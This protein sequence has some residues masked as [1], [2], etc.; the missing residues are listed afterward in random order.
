MAENSEVNPSENINDTTDQLEG[1]TYEILQNRLKK[2]ASDLQGLLKKLNEERKKVF[3]SIETVLVGTE[4]VTTDNNCVP[5]DMVPV[6][7]IFLF[8]YNVHLGLKTDTQLSDVFSIYTYHDHEFHQEDLGLIN[9]KV[10]AED[11]KKLYKYYKN[12][13]F[14]KFFKNG[15]DLHM[16]FRIGKDVT[17][18]KTFKW[19]IIGDKL[20]YIDNR[21]DHEFKFPEQHDFKWKKTTRDNFRQ[22]TFSHVSIEDKVFVE[23]TGGDLT[24]KVEDNTDDGKGIYSEPV[25]HKDQTL[26]DAE[27]YYAIVGN[28]VILKIRP[29]QED[30]RYIVFN[31]KVNQARRIDELQDSCILLPDD[32]GIIFR[33]GYYLQA[34]EFKKFDTA[35]TSMIFEK[36]IASPNG[37]DYL[38]VFYNRST[39]TY[40]LMHYN[41]IEQKVENHTICHGFSIFENGEMCLFRADEEAKKH[42][43][44]QIWQTPYTGPDFAVEGSNDSYLSKIGNK[45]VVRAMA[46]CNELLNLIHKDD[47]Y[48]GLYVDLIRI[49]TDIL[50]SYHWLNREET[51]GLN[52]PLE[53][54][55]QVA[56]SAV[57]EF[58]KVI[59]IKEATGNHIEEV[60]NTAD[61]L[62][63]RI[64]KGTAK[65]IDVYVLNLADLRKVRGQVVSLK[66]LRY[67]DLEVIDRYDDQLAEFYKNVSQDCV[68]FLL[69]DRALA[70]Y[71]NKVT[72][73]KERINEVKK[74]VEANEIEIQINKVSQELEM[75]I[76]IVSNLKI[77]DATQTTRI[78]DNIS[79]IY[80][81]FNQL[82]AALKKTRKELMGVE[83][84][85]EFNAQIKLVDQGVINFIDLCDSP[86]KCDEYLSKTM[87]QLEELEAKFSEFDEFIEKIS[88]KREEVYNAF[89][90]RKLNLIEE[91]NR[92]ANT[93][94]QAA[95]RILKAIENR[96]SRFE[97]IAEINGYYAADMMI[98]KIRGI[99]DELG[100]MGDTVKSEDIVSRLK[101]LKEDAVRQLKDRS[102]L[103]VDGQDVIKFGPHKFAVN[104]QPFDLTIVRKEDALYFH[105]AGTNFFEAIDN[106]IVATYSAVLDQVLVS[107]NDLVYRAEY[108]AYM[109]L[110]DV[111]TQPDTSVEDLYQMS[112]KDLNEYVVKF[113]SVRFDEGYIKGVHD[114]DAAHILRALVNLIH[115]SDLLRYPATA[116]AMAALFWKKY[117]SPDRKELLDHQLKGAGIILQVFPDSREFDNLLVSLRNDLLDFT[118]NTQL[119]TPEHADTAAEYLFYE[120][121]RGD[122]FVIDKEADNL[123]HAFK[124]H[125]KT[126]K[127]Q[128]QFDDSLKG[129]GNNLSQAFYHVKNWVN[130]YIQ[131]QDTNENWKDYAEEVSVILLADDY[132][133]SKVVH[134]SLNIFLEG[135]QGNHALLSDN[136]YELH[137]NH[138]TQK[139]KKYRRETVPLFEAYNRL[140]KEM[141]HDFAESLRLE[142][143]RPRIMSSFVRNR[144]IDEVYLPLIGANLAKQIG[145][146]GSEK[147]TDLMGLLLL[148]SPPG[149]G[150]TTLMEYIANRLGV[151]FMKINGPALGHDVVALD[152]KQAPNSGAREELKKLNLAFE[153]GDNVMIY[154]DDIQHCNPEFLQKFISLCDAQRK[155]E[156]V[157]KGKSRTYDFRGKRVCV[158]MAG[159][160]YTESGEKFRIPDM[161]VNRAD[162]YN[163]GDI[164]GDTEDVFKL[165]YIENCLT[166]NAVLGKLAGKS[167]KDVLSVLKIA[168]SGKQEGVDFEASH[169]PEEISEYVELIKKLLVV[170]DVILTVN[171]QYIYSAAQSDEYRTEPPFKLQ[172]SYR[173]MNKIA[174]KVVSVMNEDELQNLIIS[175]YESESQTLT[176][177]AEANLLKFK[178]LIDLMSPPEKERWEDIITLFQKKQ[179]LAGYGEGN[180]TGLVVKEMG[181]ISKHL[182]GIREEMLLL[183]LK[184][185]PKKDENE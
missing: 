48:S 166:S 63:K 39:G 51:F 30:Y 180:Q 5:C 137:F 25:D 66:E 147:R 116:R 108:L 68:G 72:A 24:I 23:T 15:V 97:S 18:V 115:T 84:K 71:E 106:D 151:I 129:Y 77:K 120:L 40:L 177:G 172:G 70:S 103:F 138:F 62:I 94:M 76:E 127:V 78:I 181:N 8:G 85:A 134:A 167:H 121:S 125:L 175:H 141:T 179:E 1:G 80:S 12:T 14:V 42:H 100:E 144:L 176:S 4:R 157:Y 10:F 95:G 33:N 41:L 47:S 2:S 158:V 46:E 161:L 123:L 168:A 142:E 162:I 140:K 182:D 91:K 130:S 124:A 143:F 52:V 146:A 9:D 131:T 150:K 114:S 96:I 38:Y 13:H 133:K 113:M 112:D 73:L 3:G 27:I 92:R 31:A 32:H 159:N 139:L 20:K 119:F 148:I 102:E 154:L 183:N 109:I 82:K 6:G 37:E 57:D 22:G 163:L 58:E 117:I 61:E 59:K 44:I 56:S 64:K 45:E 98:E 43:V 83:G 50:D 21:S 7:G 104:T 29:Y 67:A 173:D 149:Y 111:N 74:V 36:R 65:D 164:L 145:A 19:K 69:Q 185:K 28:I 35:L 49:G 16:V 152:P 118:E 93:L 55:R 34:G 165:S 54:I 153:M 174:E 101:T 178:S 160:P 105:L 89:E 155:I 169:S 11:F 75:L 53:E 184:H 107:E 135:L 81:Q 132:H 170:R 122:K 128:K 86:G 79:A 87:V 126:K 17:D 171:L 90:N 99:V 136:K 156:G 26:E 110:E 88:V 60:T